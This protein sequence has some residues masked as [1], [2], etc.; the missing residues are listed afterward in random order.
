M[1]ILARYEGQKI[2][3]NG[4]LIIGIHA[5]DCGKKEIKLSFDAPPEYIIDRQEIHERKLRGEPLRRKE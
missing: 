1:L 4:D 5:I 2:V 3:V